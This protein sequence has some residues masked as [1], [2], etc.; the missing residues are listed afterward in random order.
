MSHSTI[1]TFLIF[2]VFY[3]TFVPFGV[4][5]IRSFYHSTFLTIVPFG[6][7]SFDV[8]YFDILSVNR[9]IYRPKLG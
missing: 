3:S 7:L 1:S 2:C 6:V 8:Y 4:F 5:S 9:I